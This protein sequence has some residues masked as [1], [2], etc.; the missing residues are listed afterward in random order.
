MVSYSLVFRRGPERF[1]DQARAAGFAGAIVP[2]LPIEEADD[3][4][5]LGRRS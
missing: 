1:L 3:L 5:R 2:D 4:A